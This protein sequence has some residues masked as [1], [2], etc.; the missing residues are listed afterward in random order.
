MPDQLI[1]DSAQKMFADTCN[2]AVLDAAEAGEFPDPIWQAVRENGFHLVALPT[3][4]VGLEELF[5]VVRVA[6]RH[7][8]PVPL[9]EALLANRWLGCESGELISIGQS[10]Q[11]SAVGNEWLDVPWG[12]KAARVACVTPTN[13][14]YV[15]SPTAVTEGINMAGEPRDRLV[16][17]GAQAV[18]VSEPVFALLALARVAASTGALERVLEL[19]LRYAGEREQFGRPIARFQAIQHTLAAAAAE[20]AAAVRATDAAVDAINGERFELEVAAAKSRVGE[21]AGLVVESIHQVHGAI[22]FTHEHELHHFTR[23]LWAWREEYGGEV[24]WQRKLGGSVAALGADAVW[25]FIATP[26]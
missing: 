25:D 12:R 18:P 13:E 7:A 1:I 8:L 6:G 19:G 3:S 14:L 24:Y 22:G 21:A 26:E 2:K 23:R 20:V 4:G 9:A 16:V 10:A 11:S 17:E 5:A 15:A